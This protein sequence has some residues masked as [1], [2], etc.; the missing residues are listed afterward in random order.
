MTAHA[1]ALMFLRGAVVLVLFTAIS[2]LVQP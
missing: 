2:A 1:I